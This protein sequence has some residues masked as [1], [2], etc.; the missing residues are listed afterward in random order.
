MRKNLLWYHAGMEEVHIVRLVLVQDE[1]NH[2]EGGYLDSLTLLAFIEASSDN[3]IKTAPMNPVNHS[4][5]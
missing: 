1:P 5:I 3:K 2:Q 4:G